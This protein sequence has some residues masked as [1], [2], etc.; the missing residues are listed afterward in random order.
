MSVKSEQY[1]RPYA[2]QDLLLLRWRYAETRPSEFKIFVNDHEVPKPIFG[3]ILS[4]KTECLLVAFVNKLS[5]GQKASVKIFDTS[6]GIIATSRKRI[7]KPF[8]EYDFKSLPLQDRLRIWEGLLHKIQKTF[9]TVPDELVREIVTSTASRDAYFVRLSQGLMYFRTAWPNTESSRI[10]D[11]HIFLTFI[12]GSEKL[13]KIKSL[14]DD[15][16]IH[17]VLPIP[18]THKFDEILLTLNDG[19]KKT[20]AL[21]F[22][23]TNKLDENEPFDS[24][25]F[26]KRYGGNKALAND[27]IRQCINNVKIEA[28]SLYNPENDADGQIYLAIDSA[29]N[30]S[31]IG[32]LISG[33]IVDQNR[34][35]QSIN[36]HHPELSSIDLLKDSIK[37]P[38]PDVYSHFLT[39][40]VFLNNCALGFYRL[41]PEIIKKPNNSRID[42]TMHL[43]N[44]LQ[45]RLPSTKTQILD[46]LAP[47]PIDISFAIV[48]LLQDTKNCIPREIYHGLYT[49]LNKWAAA[50]NPGLQIESTSLIKDP[51]YLFLDTTII[52]PEAGLFISGWKIDLGKNIKS[53]EAINLTC[54]P[55]EI[56]TMLITGP[57]SDVY[58]HYYEKGL[59]IKNNEL[60]FHCLAPFSSNNDVARLS[61]L[62][63]SCRSGEV[64]RLPLNAE[65]VTSTNT[66]SVIKK[67]LLTFTQSHLSLRRLLDDCVGPAVRAIWKHRQIPD[68]KLTITSFGKTPKMPQVSIIVP[69]YGRI[70]FVLHQ[71]SLFV[72][73]SDFHKNE[74]I[75]VLDDPRLYESFIHKCYD[76]APM[77]NIPFKLVYGGYNLGFA[78]ANNIG[79]KQATGDY[80]VLLNSD[81]MPKETGWIE[82]LKNVYNK[83]PK[84]GAIGTKLLYADGSI[85]HAGMIFE[86]SHVI[87]GLWFN[88][89]PYKGNPN[90]ADPDA[91]PVRRTALTGACIMLKKAIYEEVGGFTED[92]IIGDFEDSDL[93]LKIQE[94]GYQNW[95]VPSI[96]LYH[97][98]RQS[99]LMTGEDHW[100]FH[101]TLYNCWLHS[102]KWDTT[103]I[104]I[105]TKEDNS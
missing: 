56:S 55:T 62:K 30:I 45:Y 36:L 71:L 78:G 63:I 70:D 79:V 68:L 104:E 6:D 18:K 86:K 37:V 67:I 76:I 28:L 90:H 39:R 50:S 93:C 4:D 84:A 89:H 53:I 41:I 38:R 96:E 100:R 59:L 99:Q 64:Y 61:Y 34:Q 3:I 25:I 72:D 19:N 92:Y 26:L 11:T 2:Y 1:L 33:W 47:F 69:L 5:S 17:C 91:K 77:F 20:I 46:P 57:R 42:F 58:N 24:D 7:L 75:Y 23:K 83:L 54:E 94:K 16:W 87:G 65:E 14:I 82:R 60:G 31:G 21:K 81:V 105:K 12:D 49:S 74:L 85:Q 52:I 98:E 10:I 48:E 95:Y 43:N 88:G 51:I 9:P 44:S 22:P 73:D 15:S 101:L 8:T 13:E 29:S 32:L 27:Y 97:L 80:L 40:G 103:I 66:L 35:V 102:M